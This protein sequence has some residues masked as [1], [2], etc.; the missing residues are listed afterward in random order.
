MNKIIK[1]EIFRKLF[2]IS[3][4]IIP[5]GYL[6]IINDKKLL[7]FILSILIIVSLTIE[8]LRAKSS[9]I[10]NIFKKIFGS[11]LREDESNGKLTGATWL[12]FGHLLTILIFPKSIAIPAMIFL[13]IGDASAAIVG[14]TFPLIRI[15]NKTISGSIG[16]FIISYSIMLYINYDLQQFILLCGLFSAMLIEFI[17]I[18]VNDNITIPLFSG[19]VMQLLNSII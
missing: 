3:S 6:W 5:L 19:S 17:P 7:V 11:M 13:S 1:N 15:G 8:I 10:N 9:I 4:S 14:K 12:L 16:G 18:K 2:H